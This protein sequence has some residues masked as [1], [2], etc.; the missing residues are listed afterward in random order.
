MT[1]TNDDFKS[2]TIPD[3]IE[4]EEE[5]VQGSSLLGKP[6]TWYNQDKKEHV[7][8]EEN[9][10]EEGE[11]EASP[12]PLT[13]D[14]IEAIRQ[15]AYEDGF[16]EGKEAGHA[17]G[18]EEGK[19]EGLAAG[20]QEG[21]VQG[22]AEGLAEGAE[23]IQTQLA[24]W[25][26]LLERLHNPLEKLDENAEY[27]L[28]RLAT[29]LAEQITRCEVKTSP[30]IILQALKQAVDA[31]PISQQTL[32]IN[33]HPDDLTFV[34][35]AY[36]QG[37]CERRGWNLQAEPTLLRG[38][39]QIHTEA[40]SIDYAFN[41]RIEQVLKSF[42]KDNHHLLPPKNDDSDLSN[43]QPFTTADTEHAEVV[44]ETEA[45]IEPDTSEAS[46]EVQDAVATHGDEHR[47]A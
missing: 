31:L 37:Q 26:S 20:H 12:Q 28:V 5:V 27:Q 35:E 10:L 24:S 39:C 32:I 47:N 40:S 11:E 9:A 45:T 30:Q 46:K 17:K 7:D 16:S 2:W 19:L 15:S 36:S 23:K 34:Q 25:T 1:E 43:E 8:E 18:V 38:D 22:L 14:D 33:L 21:L 44:D 3:L 6:A 42:F 41:S 4:S 13:L 29:S